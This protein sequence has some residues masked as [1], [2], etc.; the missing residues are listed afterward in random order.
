MSVL[1]ESIRGKSW[2]LKITLMSVLLGM[3]LAAALKT[4]LQVRSEGGVTTTRFD[5][6]AREY[7]GLRRENATL[8]REIEDLGQKIT[9][10]ENQL[11]SGTTAARTLNRELQDTKLLAGLTPVEGPGVIV[12]LQDSKKKAATEA[13]PPELTGLPNVWLIHDTDIQ[14]VVN[15]LEASGAEAISVNGERLI[16]MS[17]IRCVGPSTSINGSRYTAPYEIKA[18]GNPKDLENGLRMR[19]GVVDNMPDPD[20]IRIQREGRL[21]IKPFT[22]SREFKYAKPATEQGP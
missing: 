3:M 22:G 17:E 14:R 13:A 15:E 21:V 4:Q 10:Y 5:Y 20:M 12:T 19:D 16:A 1:A 2:I 8:R 7:T 11:A 9:N 6:L 18:I